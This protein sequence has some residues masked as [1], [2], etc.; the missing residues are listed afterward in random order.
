HASANLFAGILFR[1]HLIPE[2]GGADGDGLTS[3]GV[4]SLG[5]GV[6]SGK[7]ATGY[8]QYPTAPGAYGSTDTGVTRSPVNP[9]LLPGGYGAISPYQPN[10]SIH[11]RQ[12]NVYISDD[13]YGAYDYLYAN[14]ADRTLRDG[15]LL[16]HADDGKPEHALTCLAY[17]I[18]A[19]EILK[20]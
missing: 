6:V 12:P 1:T 3:Y 5:M 16:W 4:S 11:Y 13:P 7:V 8:I 19:G 9:A 10:D 15:I 17:G 14:A 18:P 2:P 20:K